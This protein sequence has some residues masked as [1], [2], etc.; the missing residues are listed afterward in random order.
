MGRGGYIFCELN[1]AIGTLNGNSS[2][3]HSSSKP[4]IDCP[5]TYTLNLEVPR[6]VCT[7]KSFVPKRMLPEGSS[8]AMAS[9]SA[10]RMTS[11]GGRA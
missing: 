6:F 2:S 4:L 1:I 3:S 11:G 7:S 5:K 9:S 8:C 10:S